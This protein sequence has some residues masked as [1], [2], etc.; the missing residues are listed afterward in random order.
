M[1]KQQREWK[2]VAFFL[3]GAGDPH[4]P[5]FGRMGE[6]TGGHSAGGKE[7]SLSSG[8]RQD[9]SCHPPHPHFPSDAEVKVPLPPKHVLCRFPP[10]AVDR[11]RP[12][13]TQGLTVPTSGSR[14]LWGLSPLCASGWEAELG[15]ARSQPDRHRS[16]RV[17]P[18]KGCFS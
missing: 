1:Q 3:C 14:F 15:S 13:G 12:L 5:T 7:S 17:T 10:G 16:V 6:W 4:H 18:S 8:G 11:K 9:T 2:G